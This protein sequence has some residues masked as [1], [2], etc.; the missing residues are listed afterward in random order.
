MALDELSQA[1]MAGGNTMQAVRLLQ[2][3]ERLIP[4]NPFIL[5]RRIEGQIVAGVAEAAAELVRSAAQLTNAELLFHSVELLTSNGFIDEA[6][7]LTRASGA[8]HPHP[9][10]V[11]A[12]C[13]ARVLLARGRLRQAL[14]EVTVLSSENAAHP[15]ALRY[16]QVLLEHLLDFAGVDAVG[17][18]ITL[19]GGESFDL[20]R[21]V[22]RLSFTFEH[23]KAQALLQ[24]AARHHPQQAELVRS[25]TARL[26]AENAE[27]NAAV[28]EHGPLA[29][30]NPDAIHTALSQPG[31]SPSRIRWGKASLSAFLGTDGMTEIQ[32]NRFDWFLPNWEDAAVRHRVLAAARRVCPASIAV[33]QRW[34]SYLMILGAYADAAAECHEQ[35]G[36]GLAGE[37]GRAHV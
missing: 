37:I 29:V 23:A 25:L 16:R 22:E 3:L 36:D 33:R 13:R 11:L 35:L 8:A 5:V 15:I 7:A 6:E 17:H 30:S 12:A 19:R 27:L 2:V 20:S 28:A 14:K 1:E 18:E 34:L 4:D 10:G 26:Q 9:A 31:A 32:F 21:T 24:N